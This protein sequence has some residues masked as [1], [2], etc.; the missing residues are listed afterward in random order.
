M[1]FIV[2]AGIYIIL[3]SQLLFYTWATMTSILYFPADSYF[4]PALTTYR[5]FHE[6]FLTL[7]GTVSECQ[8]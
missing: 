2:L 8:V 6:N 3:L 4:I 1:K 7:Y 5:F